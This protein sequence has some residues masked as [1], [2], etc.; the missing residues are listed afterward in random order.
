MQY[1]DVWI[2]AVVILYK[3]SEPM[4]YRSITSEIIDSDLTILG[5]KGKTPEQTVGA[6]LRG[7]PGVFHKLGSGYYE[8]ASC[9]EL[10]KQPEI[11]QAIE[12]C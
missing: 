9:S 5:S 8:L 11:R 7:K 12:R 3:S 10:I 4:H 1:F 6:I 2:A